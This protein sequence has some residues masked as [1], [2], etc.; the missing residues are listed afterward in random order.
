MRRYPSCMATQHPDNSQKY[1]TIQ[2]E[3][4]EAV[5]DLNLQEKGG[6][7]IEEVMVDF[8]GKLTPYHQTSQITLGLI[9]EGFTPGEDVFVTPR[10]PNAIKEP[11]FRQLMSIMSLVET[12][13]LAYQQTGK[14][15]I[16]ETIIPMIE[17][18]EEL[19]RIQERVNSIIDL[20]NKNYDIKFPLNSI[21]L[22]PLMEGIPSLV[23]IDKIIDKYYKH[24][25][26]KDYK[27][28]DLRVMI[29]RSDS[30]MSY[31]VV[32]SVL[33]VRMA[34]SK[35]HK[36]GQEND[37]EIAPILGCGSL[38]FRG[39]LSANNI[40][41]TFKTYAGIKT[42]T[43]QSGLKYDHGTEE[44]REVVNK[45]KSH[46]YM[47]NFKI[48]SEEEMDLM[49]EYIGVFSKHYIDIFTRVIQ[50]I[51]GIS[52][53]IPKNRDRLASSKSGLQYVR[54]A[55]DVTEVVE[56]VKD[57]KLK[58]ELLSLNTDV[59]CSV[60]RAITFTAS[61]YTA[62]I[63]PEFLGVGRG[64]REIKEK[65]GQEGIDK[66]LEFYP[67]LIDDLTFAARYTNTKISKGIVN[68]ESRATY[69][70]DFSLAC[71]ILGILAKDY[72][73]EEFY[74]TLLKSVR[75]ILL[76]LMG[77]EEEMFDDVEEEMKILKEWIVKLGK[78]RGSLG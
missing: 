19:I 74:H 17:S 13:M 58:E 26:S 2:Q 63:T 78:L 34:I 1:I 66:L 60:P 41:N 8:E 3:P 39:H 18:G 64:L 29:A 62:G 56:L 37:V 49:S 75:P 11:V 47:E 65:Y 46:D 70:E 73:E 68:E 36:W 20:G 72:P 35:I 57:P 76:H 4:E 9:N 7:G 55:I 59:N 67:S 38:P 27:L 5:R 23:N 40:E 28:R 69:K 53:F 50:D 21:K 31:G 61:M 32:S 51:D 24:L 52:K 10:I 54:E 43:I 71:D 48:L 33:A 77:K 22:I 16:I 30:A 44:T 42:F 15:A 12:N 45:L 14:Q 6:L 25:C